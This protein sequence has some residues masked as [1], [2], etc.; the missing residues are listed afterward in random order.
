MHTNPR[1]SAITKIVLHDNE[2]PEGINSAFDLAVYLHNN[3]PD[4]GGYQATCDDKL[5]VMVVPDDQVCWANGAIN[6]T[7]IDVCVVGYAAQTPEQWADA[8]DKSALEKMAQWVATKCTYYAIPAV[9]LQGNDLHD[10]NKRGITTHG[11]LTAAGYAGTQGHTDPGVNFPLA[12]FIARVNQILNPPIDWGAIARIH[13]WV[14]RLTA[15]PLKEGD[16]SADVATLA[17]WLAANGQDPGSG[18][19]YGVKVAAAVA[20]FKAQWALDNRDGSVC[21]ADCANALV[22]HAAHPA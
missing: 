10:P 18:D 12:A 20:R 13:S 7:S 15:T 14:L 19:A 16:R 1:Q 4:G 22:K 21:G 9:L 8:F 2:G 5:C 3:G 11:L 6:E 17:E